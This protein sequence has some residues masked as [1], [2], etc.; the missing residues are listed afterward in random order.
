METP[1]TYFY[2]DVERSVKANV[3]FPK[4]MLTEFYPPVREMAPAYDAEAAQQGD[5][6]P[7]GNGMLDWGTIQ[8]IPTSALRPNLSDRKT[9]AFLQ[10]TI[11]REILLPADGNHYGYARETDSALVY[12][13]WPGVELPEWIVMP[14][15]SPSGAVK[16]AP[17]HY[18]EKFLFYRGVGQF[19]VPVDVKTDGT[20]KVTIRNKGQQ[21]LSGL[22]LLTVKDD[23]LMM[24]R[25]SDCA[26]HSSNTTRLPAES[27]SFETLRGAMIEKLT[28]AGLYDK[29]A[30]AMVNTWQNSWFTEQGTR[31]FYLVPQET[32]D[33][34]LPLEISPKPDQTVR[35]MVGRVEIMSATLE[36]QL[37]TVLKRSVQEREAAYAKAVEEQTAVPVLPLPPEFAAMGR[38]AEPALAR[39]QAIATEREISEEAE[40]FLDQITSDSGR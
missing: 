21:A 36:K 33:E 23:Q 39:L 32:T 22:I 5:G 13:R 10:E 3:R 30:I 27:V 4:G 34:L 24:T 14:E 26:P 11:A 35:V 37:M 25:V 20:G 40:A 38:I 31:L 7:I 15:K 8:L 9:S 12:T 18:L 16:P 1:V 28:A 19:D 6:E 17:G 29:E 2:T